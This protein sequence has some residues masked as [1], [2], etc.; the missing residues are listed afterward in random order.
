MSD[1]LKELA[2][3][4]VSYSIN[5]EKNEKVLITAQSLEAREFIS[6]LI[7]N[8]YQCG[9]IPAVRIND[10]LLA[11]QLAEGNTEERIKLIKKLQEQEVENYDS[12]ISI[13]YG[14]NDY[15]TKNVPVEI[16]KKLKKATEKSHDIRVNERKWVILN[17]PSP[18]LTE[19][20]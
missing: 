16:L 14:I 10:P 12:F 8:I 2:D 9:G 3:M 13:A 1:K 20:N 6:Y 15:E 7:E 4:V 18:T 17:F 11:S 19:T 5:V